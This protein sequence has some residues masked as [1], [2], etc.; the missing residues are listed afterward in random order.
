MLGKGRPFILELKNPKKREINL[1]DLEERINKN[2]KKIGV[3]NLKFSNKKEI[4]KIKSKNYKK[5]YLIEIECDKN[6][7]IEK[8]KK[9]AQSL[10]GKI[11][12]QYTPTRVARR[13]ANLY[14]NKKIYNIEIKS[15]VK[16]VATL[17][18][19][20]QSGTYIKELITGDNGKTKPNISECYGFP[21]SVK[22]LD[23]ISIKV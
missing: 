4:K 18:I 8:L 21:C 17:K 23:V 11:I 20:S 7:D 16:K 2:N 9:A 15:V 13:R 5:E 10:R 6:I 14:R 22:K 19:E 3:N 12:N 1:K